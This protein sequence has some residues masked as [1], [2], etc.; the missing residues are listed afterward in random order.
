VL[1]LTSVAAVSSTFET[2][3]QLPL[4]RLLLFTGSTCREAFLRQFEVFRRRCKWDNET[5]AHQ[6]VLYLDGSPQDV[7]RNLSFEELSNYDSVVRAVEV[8]FAPKMSLRSA[9]TI[10][11]TGFAERASLCEHWPTTLNPWATECTLLWLL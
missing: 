7:L 6:L 11:C 4:A 5:S 8:V 2:Q 9:S 3:T 10:F 1:S